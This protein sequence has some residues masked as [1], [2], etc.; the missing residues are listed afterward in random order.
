M[1]KLVTYPFDTPSMS[2]NKMGKKSLI[3][4]FVVALSPMLQ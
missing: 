4:M 3:N 1:H 2:V